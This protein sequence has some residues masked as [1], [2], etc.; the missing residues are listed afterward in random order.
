MFS[1]LGCPMQIF[2]PMVSKSGD[3]WFLR[4]WTDDFFHLVISSGKREGKDIKEDILA[5]SSLYGI[6][7]SFNESKRLK[8]EANVH[9]TSLCLR[10]IRYFFLRNSLLIRLIKILDSPI[11][12]VSIYLSNIFVILVTLHVINEIPKNKN[13]K[14][15]QPFKNENMKTDEKGNRP[16]G[17]RRPHMTPSRPL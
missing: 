15:P 2:Y 17:L 7:I 1:Y 4:N 3:C 6:F 16:S 13:R 9:P 11:L 5:S 12:T 10:K 8:S 14:N